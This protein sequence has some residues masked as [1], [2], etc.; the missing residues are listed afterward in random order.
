M[1]NEIIDENERATQVADYKRAIE[2][3]VLVAHDPVPHELLAQLLEQPTAL[4]EQWCD[5]LARRYQADRNGFEMKR[6]AGG[7]RFQTAPRPSPRTWNA[8][9]FTT[10]EPGCRAP[11]SRHWPSSRTSSRSLA[12]RSQ[13]SE[14][15]T[16]TA[17]CELFKLGTTSDEIGRDDGPGQAILFGTTSSFLEKLGLESIDDLPPIAEF[18]PGPE[19][20]EALEHG[21]RVTPEVDVVAAPV[22]DTAA[23]TRAGG[24]GR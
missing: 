9:C 11:L 19:V 16:R 4:V 7:V 20:V 24:T 21:L 8:S 6:V 2:A 5:E 17:S 18:I 10:S 3:I 22:D 13:R 14:A 12:P 23:R 15:S 1:T